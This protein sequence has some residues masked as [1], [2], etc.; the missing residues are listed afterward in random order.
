M[1]LF[2]NTQDSNILLYGGI[3]NYYGAVIPNEQANFYLKALLEK[4]EWKND[5]AIIF[6]KSIITKRKVAWY[7]NSSFSY[8][9]SNTTKQTG[10]SLDERIIR[11]KIYY[12]RQV[13]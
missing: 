3:V 5:E 6:G 12:R 4:I 7:G 13:P 2:N 10:I 11:I 8:T 1:D 9:Y